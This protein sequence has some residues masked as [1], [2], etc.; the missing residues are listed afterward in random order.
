MS[1]QYFT[2]PWLTKA[3]LPEIE[4]LLKRTHI[5]LKWKDISILEPACGDGAM[6]DELRNTWPEA[7]ITASDITTGVDFLNMSETVKYDIIVSNPPYK[8]A[9]PFVQKAHRMLKPQGIICFLLRMNWLASKTRAEW[10]RANTP[11]VFVSPRRPKFAL[12][13][14]GVVSS[15]ACEYAWMVWRPTTT[16]FL[17]TITI[18]ETDKVSKS[19]LD[20]ASARVLRTSV[21]LQPKQSELAKLFKM[22]KNLLD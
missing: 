4:R 21:V 17:P 18:L 12:N 7:Q 3:V 16:L 10:L 13:K 20:E 11:A 15:D 22:R 14:H 8:L 1:D 19:E 5:N 6:V 2:P 9:M